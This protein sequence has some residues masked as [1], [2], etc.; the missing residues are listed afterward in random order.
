MP[1]WGVCTSF[2]KAAE[3]KAAG[4]DYVE[5]TV[6]KIVE[7]GW[8]AD[9][10]LPARAANVLMPA[11]LKITGPNVDRAKLLAHVENVAHKSMQ[12]GL[13]NVVFGS[14]AARNVPDGFDRTQAEDQIRDFCNLL[15]DAADRHGI[16]FV[17]EPL[18]RRE[19]NIINSVAEAMIYV[20]D[21]NR[22]GVQCLVDSYHFWLEDES[23]ANLEAA[24]PWIKH[25]H[26]ADK[27]GRTAPGESGQPEVS[28]YNAFFAVLKRHDYKGR[29]S[30]EAGKFDVADA[31][32]RS[33]AYLKN[34]WQLA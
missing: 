29:I 10:P 11:D 4:F 5:P 7:A 22:P 16:T 21:T 24:M 13:E 8:P 14:G 34:Q 12:A 26:V 15:A 9:A 18:N 17:I 32:V 30:I 27:E 25:V 28:N 3:V 20:R 1:T 2:E 6:G 33:L 31:G 23:L 19:C